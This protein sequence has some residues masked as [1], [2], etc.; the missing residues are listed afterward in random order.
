ME[1]Y[2]FTLHQFTPLDCGHMESPHSPITRGYGT[3]NNGKKLCYECCAEGDKQTMKETG[4]ATLYF[5]QR[6]GNG[7]AYVT[8]WPGS[9]SIP[10][11]YVKK[12]RHNI[13]RIRY[14]YWFAFEGYWWHG[15]TVGNNTQIAHCKRTKE[16][17]CKAV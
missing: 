7:K 2:N 5:T 9:L 11:A 17:T 12:G 8:N 1:A 3:D 16:P 4:K 10:C 15:Y 13:A 6:A 14:D